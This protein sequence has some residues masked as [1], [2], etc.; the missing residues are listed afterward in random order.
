LEL[1]DLFL[2]PIYLLFLY[3]I[4]YGIRPKVTTKSTRKYFIPA[5]TLKIIGAICL[6]LVYQFYYGGGDTF[7]YFNHVKVV[8]K[9]FL[10]SPFVAFKIIFSHGEYDPATHNYTSW[11][12]WYHS[13]TEFFVVKVASLLSFI[14]F[15]TYTVI[16][17]FF[18]FLSFTGMWA[19]YTTFLKLYPSLY[20][21]FAIAVFF[22]PSVFFWGSGLMKDSLTIGALGWLFYSFYN[23]AIIKKKI[24]K[25]A[26]IG[27][28]AAY[29]IYTVKVYVLLSFLPPAIFWVFTENSQKIKDATIRGILK[30]LFIGVGLVMAYLG[31]TKLTEGDVRYDVNKIAERS[32]INNTYLSQQVAS[33]SAYNIGVFDGSIRSILTVGPQAIVVAL[34]RPFLF[35]VRNPLMLLSA[36]EGSV[37]IY[38]TILFIYKVGFIKTLK[39]I[40]SKP[41]LTFCMI[42]SLALAFA[43]GTNSGNFGSLVRYKIP[44][45]PFYLAALFIMQAHLK[46]PKKVARLA[47]TA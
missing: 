38:L 43:V 40:R 26:L 18:A 35:E 5:L 29:I 44:L 27:F 31:A 19:M 12:M 21:Q 30:P 13:P 42:F 41:I 20:K 28:L 17:V 23:V 36:L 22:L 8:H 46:R 11:L 39:F 14:S 3:A 34:Y 6:G 47:T 4:A 1:K 16:A 32:R 9:A 10:D 45:M 2:T 25:S 33:G 7:S 15:N 37:F 24:F